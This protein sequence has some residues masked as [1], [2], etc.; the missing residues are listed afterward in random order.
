MKAGPERDR[1]LRSK[2]DPGPLPAN[3]EDIA[4]APVIKL[5][6]WIELRK[7]SSER[8]TKLYLERIEKFDPK[9]HCVITVTRE[10]ALTQAKKAD[11]EIEAVKNTAGRYTAFLGGARI[12]WTQL[13]SRPRTEPSPSRTACPPPTLQWYGA[14]RRLAQ[15][16]SPS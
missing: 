2:I 4:F 10:L 16:S 15:Y 12:S 14:S 9:L 8:I 13:E 5:S 7:L 3:D 1:F 11:A 6:R